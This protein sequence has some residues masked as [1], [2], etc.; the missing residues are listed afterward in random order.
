MKNKR[1][2]ESIPESKPTH[3]VGI[4][5]L[6]PEKMT[7]ILKSKWR[8]TVKMV[9][10]WY[11]NREC[12]KKECQDLGNTCGSGWLGKKVKTYYKVLSKSL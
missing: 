12:T 2:W 10:I 7:I 9:T 11:A 8:K 4:K 1:D 5:E 3:I 6:I